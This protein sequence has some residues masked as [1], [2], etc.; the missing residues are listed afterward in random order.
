MKT[1]CPHCHTK[2]RISEA[3]LEAA[4]GQAR[5]GKCG[6]V[7][8]AQSTL[9]DVAAP[10]AETPLTV[11]KEPAPEFD[12]ALDMGIE[13]PTMAPDLLQALER[14][15]APPIDDLFADLLPPAAEPAVSGGETESKS[16]TPELDISPE[17]PSERPEEIFSG[18]AAE[19]SPEKIF[20]STPVELHPLLPPTS[21]PTPAH[22]LLRAAWLVGTLLMA[23]LLVTQLA[24]ANRATLARNLVLGPSL[25]A[26][27]SALGRPLPMPNSITAWNVAALNVTS[28]PQAPGAL[29]ITGSLENHADF[30]QDWPDLR[31]VLSDQNGEPLRSR[32]FKPAEYLPANQANVLLPGGQAVRFRMDIVDPGP[33]AVGFAL[34]P[35]LDG[36]S[37]RICAAPSM[38][39]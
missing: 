7:F 27:Y 1:T 33:D 25:R 31:V 4:H 9:H 35:C 15:P 17:H 20:F 23:L 39:D 16:P 22:P 32:D 13:P 10:A 29:S 28:D 19:D 6:E 12:V 11:E 2:F 21:P 5:C 24:D 3:Q 26:L 38:S 14:K 30:T 18:P 34:T 37:G 8:D 36:P